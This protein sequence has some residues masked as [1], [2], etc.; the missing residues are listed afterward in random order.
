MTALDRGWLRIEPSDKSHLLLDFI[1][2]YEAE[3]R[4][5]GVALF[6]SVNGQSYFM[7]APSGLL[8]SASET[9]AITHRVTG[10]DEVSFGD[11]VY[12]WGDLNA[13][14]HLDHPA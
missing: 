12:V 2:Y 7:C 14:E 1:R 8:A 11:L 13:L 4:P 3:K 5:G 10:A 9:F 6:E